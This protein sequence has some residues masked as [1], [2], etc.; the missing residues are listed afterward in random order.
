VIFDSGCA[1][2]ISYHAIE[3][4]GKNG[5]WC[6]GGGGG[7]KGVLFLLPT[8]SPFYACYAGYVICG[9]TDPLRK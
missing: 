7:G 6:G 1:L 4:G 3:I 2:V 5:K 9:K 8:P